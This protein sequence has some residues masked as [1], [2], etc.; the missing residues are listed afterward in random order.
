MSA[1]EILCLVCYFE[2]MIGDLVNKENT[3]WQFCLI[4]RKNFDLVT[5]KSILSKCTG[6]LSTSTSLVTFISEQNETCQKLINSCLSLKPKLHFNLQYP[7]LM[8][9]IRPFVHISSMRYEA[10]H[11]EFKSNTHVISSR[12]YIILTVALVVILFCFKELHQI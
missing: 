12:K 2:V 4:L 5:C 7:H 11:K 6:L 10:K 8:F 9:H 3:A 1:Y